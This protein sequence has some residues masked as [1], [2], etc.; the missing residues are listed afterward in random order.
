MMTF[1]RRVEDAKN[2][3]LFGLFTRTLEARI[4]RMLTI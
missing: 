4:L 1:L 3:R 2:E